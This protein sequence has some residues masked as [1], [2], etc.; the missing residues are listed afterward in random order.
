MLI[1]KHLV[2]GSEMSYGRW[3]FCLYLLRRKWGGARCVW[4]KTFSAHEIERRPRGASRASPL[5]HLLQ[6]AVPVGPWLLALAHGPRLAGRRQRQP[7]NRVV[8]TRLTTMA[9][10]AMARCNKCRSGLARDAPRGRRSISW[11]LNVLSQTHRAP[12]HF[13]PCDHTQKIHLP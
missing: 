1:L 11:A 12:P 4:L 13:L 9:C 6:R 3:I 2:S 10:Q 5:L 8:P 7:K